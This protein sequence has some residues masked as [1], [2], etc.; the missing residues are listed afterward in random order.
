MAF[1]Q[2]KNITKQ[3]LG[4]NKPT[5]DNIS[6][7]LAHNQFIVLLGASG[8]GKSTLLNMIAG[9]EQPDSGKIILDGNDIT[10]FPPGQRQLSMVFQSYALFPHLTVTE[11][12]LFGLKA[13]KIAVTER[14]KR[15][16]N[17][18]EL[19]S[20]GSE[21]DKKPA[22]LS[23]GQRQRVAL[24]RA[25]VAQA[26]LCLMDEPLSNLDAKLRQEMRTEIRALQQHLKLSVLYVTHDQI[27]AMS[28]AD[29]ILLLH[30]GKIAQQATPK[31]L[32]A[33]PE[34]IFSATFIGSPPMN[35]LK[36]D[37]DNVLLGIRPEHIAL[38]DNQ[39][40]TAVQ[41]HVIR[42]DYHGSDTLITAR[43]GEQSLKVSLAGH[44]DYLPDTTLSLH[45]PSKHRHY[46][47]ADSGNAIA[48]DKTVLPSE[49]Q[50]L[51]T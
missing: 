6:F 13:R 2:L 35:V 7:S 51:T 42:Q 21:I 3:W 23:G 15:L 29:K 37:K 34:N 14:Q 20:L 19:V 9:L 45:L 5:V 44:H 40:K 50:F 1:L 41:T 8:C 27:E 39:D 17:A 24:A 11:N 43:L 38:A 30:D 36:T 33:E 18:L 26:P 28:M 16:K 4:N 22:Q 47:A 10:D 12:I 31:A 32:Y 49:H 48:V 46:F 25:I